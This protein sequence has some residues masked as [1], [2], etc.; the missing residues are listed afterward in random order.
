MASHSNHRR[1][2]HGRHGASTGS[3]E[4]PSA[5][6]SQGVLP[7]HRDGALER[8]DRRIL[9]ELQRDGATSNAALGERVAISESAATR[10]RHRLERKGYIKRYAAVV[11]IEQ[12]G[13]RE[14][15]LVEV[16]LASQHE[17]S[18]AAF[19]RSV[20]EVPEVLAVY[21]I[22]GQLDY[23][24]HIVARDTHDLERI[25]HRLTALPGVEH[26]HTHVVLKNVLNREVVDPA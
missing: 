10:H 7:S 24:L 1:N 4:E 9:R 5:G 26:L 8:V 3:V 13:Y 19:E 11:D 25:Q 21:A 6:V 14:T 15:A 22:A 16:G 2:S 18:L 23:L 20:E 12:L 17:D